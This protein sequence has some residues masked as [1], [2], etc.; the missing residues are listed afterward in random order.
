LISIIED[1]LDPPPPKGA[2]SVRFVD[3]PED[4]CISVF[5]ISSSE[6]RPHAIGHVDGSLTFL[7][8]DGGIHPLR[9]SDLRLEMLGSPGVRDVED[10]IKRRVWAI[11]AGRG[12]VPLI[13][14]GKVIV[15]IVPELFERGMLGIRPARIMEGLSDFEWAEGEWLEVI[16]GYLGYYSD[17]SYVHLGNNGSLEAVESF[18]MMPKRGGEMVLDLLLY[19]N[20]IARIIRSYQDALSDVDLAPKLFFSLSLANVL[21][22]KMGLRMRGKHTK[23]LSDVLNLPPRPLATK[24]D[25]DGVMTFVNSFLDILW[26]GS[27]V[28]PR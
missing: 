7:K 2:Y 6:H 27:G 16:D 26:H 18:K 13:S 9:A 28:R 17:Y 8:Q 5:E 15:H 20:D 24:C 21:G 3:M 25:H 19:Q 10:H 23:F 11:S 1:S 12:K 22:Y 14:T 4:R